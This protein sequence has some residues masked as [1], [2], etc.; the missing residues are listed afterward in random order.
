MTGYIKNPT[1]PTQDLL[2]SIEAISPFPRINSKEPRSE[3]YPDRANDSEKEK[4]DQDPRR[5][6]KLRSLI[7]EL[8]ASAQINKVDMVTADAEMQNLG[9]AIVEENLIPHLLQLKIPLESIEHLVQQIDSDPSGIRCARDRRIDS[10]NSELFP[11]SAEG[12]IEYNL[13]VE[14]LIISSG[15]FSHKIVDEIDQEGLCVKQQNR[16]RLIFSRA[17]S[18]S[19]ASEELLNLKISVLLGVVES[20]E[21]ERRAI[22]YPQTAKSYGLYADKRISLSI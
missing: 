14:R 9:L 21:V 4:K 1:L 8:E 16:L 6:L 19:G 12:L 17:G 13:I 3:D 15:K 10:G 22:L 11:I 7:K 5:F 2:R 20:D 18:T